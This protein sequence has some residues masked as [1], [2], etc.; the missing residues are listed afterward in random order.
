MEKVFYTGSSASFGGSQ[1]RSF[2][3]KKKRVFRKV[4]SVL[5]VLFVW[6]RGARN[7]KDLVRYSRRPW[8]LLISMEL[9]AFIYCNRDKSANI[10]SRELHKQLNDCKQPTFRKWYGWPIYARWL[11][12]NVANYSD[13]NYRK[14]IVLTHHKVLCCRLVLGQKYLPKPKIFRF[15]YSNVVFFF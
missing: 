7:R 6:L 3:R 10:T 14:N 4:R 2:F 15:I 1:V 12:F 13:P 8:N 5:M 9:P 11:I